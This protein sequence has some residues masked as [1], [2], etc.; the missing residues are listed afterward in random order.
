[1]L[2]RAHRGLFEL[3]NLNCKLE[4]GLNVLGA[5]HRRIG[6]LANLPLELEHLRRAGRI[7]H[8]PVVIEVHVL[9]VHN[10]E[11]QPHTLSTYALAPLSNLLLGALGMRQRVNAPECHK[12]EIGVLHAALLVQKIEVHLGVAELKE[13]DGARVLVGP[14]VVELVA[15]EDDPALLGGG[16]GAG[17]LLLHEV[18]GLDHVLLD[19]HG[20]VLA[21][22]SDELWRQNFAQYFH[23]LFVGFDTVED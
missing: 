19:V 4:S 18:P 13:P 22:D 16:E 20:H 14:G 17:D 10:I 11:R 8:R 23:P 12:L 7:H 2:K 9:S 21:L 5:E 3:Q 6:A 15:N 1:M